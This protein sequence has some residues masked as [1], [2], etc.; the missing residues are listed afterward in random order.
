[1]LMDWRLYNIPPG[2]QDTQDVSTFL[3]PVEL[4]MMANS[5]CLANVS[6]AVMLNNK[7]DL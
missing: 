3:R 7:S 4:K 5:M 6:T 1:M 2:L